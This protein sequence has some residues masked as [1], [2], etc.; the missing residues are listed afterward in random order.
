M[1]DGLFGN[2]DVTLRQGMELLWDLLTRG[3]RL[4]VAGLVGAMALTAVFELLGIFS[5]VPFIGLVSNPEL[6]EESQWAARV[7]ELVGFTSVTAFL[8]AT[9][10]AVLFLL[11]FSNAFSAFA[12]WLNLRFSWATYH[13]LSVDLLR[14]YLNRP[15]AYYLDRNTAGLGKNILSEIGSV[16]SGVLMPSL[17]VLTKGIAAAGIL[18]VLVAVDPVLALIVGV[19][20]GGAYAVIYRVVRRGQNRIGRVR[21]DAQAAR[22]RAATEPL[23]GIKDVKVLGREEEFVQRYS[24]PSRAFTEA[25]ATN[26]AVSQLPRYALESLAFGGILLIV[27][28]LL[29]FEQDFRGALPMMTLYAVAGYRLMPG[30]QQIFQGVTQIRFQL[31]ALVEVHR[32]LEGWRT[33]AASVPAGSSPREEDEVHVR[34]DSVR[35]TYPGAEAPAIREV[36]LEVPRNRTVGLVGATGAGKTTLVDLILGLLPVDQ[37]TILLDGV[38]VSPATRGGLAGRLGYVPQ[39]IYLAD[40]TVRRNIAFG[41]PDEDIDTEA[42]ERAA[43]IAKV[44][45]FV[46]SLPD[47]YE[48]VVGERGVRFSGGQRQRIGIARALYHDPSVLILDEATS[49]LDGVTEGTVMEAI[50]ELE[51]QKTIIVIAHRLTTVRHCDTIFLLEDGRVADAGRYDDLLER[52]PRF[53]AMAGVR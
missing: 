14:R 5:I 18:A 32:D 8:T 6:V 23:S 1:K 50:R 38:E 9:G 24:R 25:M 15:Y 30:L 10:F 17:L 52:N 47:G 19:V 42:V 51:H 37:G 48:Q 49:A 45:D 29:Q 7:Y 41:V 27:L 31:P 4:R 34:L 36:S 20:L 2:H 3:E 44:A 35:F 12:I 16:V 11:A 53:R 28:Y 39:D 46:E 22:F 13:R 26:G 33:G 21:V 40:D 43:R